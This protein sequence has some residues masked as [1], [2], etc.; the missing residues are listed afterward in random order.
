MEKG[1]KANGTSAGLACSDI[2]RVSPGLAEG[3]TN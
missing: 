1:R 2:A 3:R